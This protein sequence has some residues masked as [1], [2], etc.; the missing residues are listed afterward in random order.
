MKGSVKFFDKTKGFGFITVDDSDE[1]V[2][3]HQTGILQDGFRCLQRGQKVEFEMITEDD[4]KTKAI[5]A[6]KL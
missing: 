5:N 1:S 2:F 3:V 4:E 6:T